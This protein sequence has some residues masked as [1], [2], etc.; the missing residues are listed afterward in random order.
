MP[1]E[2][3][4]TLLQEQ[5]KIKPNIEDVILESLDGNK[6]TA[7]LDFVAYMRENKMTLRWAGFTNAWK[8]MYKGKCI[9]YVRLKGNSDCVEKTWVITLWLT[10]IEEY[11]ESIM[12]EKLQNVVWDN[13][14]N[15]LFCRTPCHGSPPGTDIILLGKEIKS[16][17]SNRQP[18]WAY[19][20]D[21]AT[22]SGIKRL[23]Q[24]E[25][26]ARVERQ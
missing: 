22:I 24:L 21:Q 7:A 11:K 16:V 20:P 25:Q 18:V 23:L 4:L 5:K 12:H 1:E 26:K 14:F 6:R 15:C 8:A 9:C 19:D 17:C 13:V 10:Y 2:K 3:K